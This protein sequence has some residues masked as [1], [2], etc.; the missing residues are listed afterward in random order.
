MRLRGWGDVGA[1]SAAPEFCVTAGILRN[2]E[3][4]CGA[5]SWCRAAWRATQA[6]CA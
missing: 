3:R 1:V 4:T 2:A 5:L 6:A